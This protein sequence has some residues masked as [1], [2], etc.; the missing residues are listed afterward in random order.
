[1]KSINRVL[2][3][4]YAGGEPTQKETKSGSMA[5]FDLATNESYLNKNGE[6]QKSTEWHK[7]IIW[8]KFVEKFSDKI[9]KGIR[10][11]VEGKIKTV[12][13]DDREGGKKKEVQI[14]ANNIIIL[15]KKEG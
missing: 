2:L 7:V 12:E 6:W 13:W 15:D 1:M 11:I 9:S 10:L 3:L 5:T 4:G 8:N 14:W